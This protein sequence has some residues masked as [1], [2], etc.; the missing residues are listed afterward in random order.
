[1]SDGEVMFQK[2]SSKPSSRA[3]LLTLR[4]LTPNVYHRV[5]KFHYDRVCGTNEN[6]KLV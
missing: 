6:G 5:E 4:A 1:M 2:E 3:S